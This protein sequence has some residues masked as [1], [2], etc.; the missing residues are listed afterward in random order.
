MWKI[1][2]KQ[3]KVTQF[4]IQNVKFLIVID[5]QST[6]DAEGLLSTDFITKNVLKA[7]KIKYIKTDY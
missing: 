4:G 3:S 2:I 5:N 7:V 6:N 1:K